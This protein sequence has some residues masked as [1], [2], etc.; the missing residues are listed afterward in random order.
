MDINRPAIELE[1][2]RQIKERDGRSRD[3]KNAQEHKFLEAE[4]DSFLDSPD[5][6]RRIF[7][8]N[9]WIRNIALH[10]WLEI[11]T[12]R[13]IT[14]IEIYLKE[15]KFKKLFWQINMIK[16]ALCHDLKLDRALKII[17]F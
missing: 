16:G 1:K 12:G 4:R 6:L 9:G 7:E 3:W 10:C 15:R 2:K 8:A 5:C 13:R 17:D 14:D 11:K